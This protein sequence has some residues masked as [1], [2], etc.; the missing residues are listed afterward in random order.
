MKILYSKKGASLIEVLGSVLIFSIA[1]QALLA[2][3]TQ[4]STMGKRSEYVYTAY[5]LAKNHVERLKTLDF[6]D[7][8]S[9]AESSTL[10]NQDG[11]PDPSGTYSRT[12]VVSPN[13][14]GNV[15]LAQVTVTVHYML[16]GIQSGTPM[17]ITTVIM[18][19]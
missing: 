2:I 12:T 8:S 3:Y 11:E 5:N 15:L 9:A 7:L 10:L 13:Y 17:Q 18:D 14:S 6:A 16:K 19:Q 4:S 1:M